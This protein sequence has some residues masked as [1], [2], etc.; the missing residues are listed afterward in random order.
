MVYDISM[1]Q[2]RSGVKLIDLFKNFST[3]VF[4][5]EFYH[6]SPSDACL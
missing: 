1:I 2:M 5:K 3:N 4:G 6:T